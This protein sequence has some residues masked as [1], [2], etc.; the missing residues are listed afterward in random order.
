MAGL[1]GV[2]F[3]VNAEPV[4]AGEHLA[5]HITGVLGPGVHGA[6]MHRKGATGAQPGATHLQTGRRVT[7]A[8]HIVIW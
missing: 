7:V 3:G 2:Y 4:R 1:T 8:V 6:H 5:A